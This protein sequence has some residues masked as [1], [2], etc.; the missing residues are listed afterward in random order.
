MSLDQ[1][2]DPTPLGWRDSGTGVLRFFYRIESRS[3][4]TATATGEAEVLAQSRHRRSLID[5]APKARKSLIAETKAMAL[6]RVEPKVNIVEGYVLQNTLWCGHS[7]AH[8]HPELFAALLQTFGP[9]C[10]RPGIAISL[11][12]GWDAIALSVLAVASKEPGGHL[13]EGVHVRSVSMADANVRIDT[14]SAALPLS[15]LLQELLTR[16]PLPKVHRIGFSVLQQGNLREVDVDIDGVTRV[17][18]APS[19]AGLWP[20]R[21]LRRHQ[22]AESLITRVSTAMER[23]RDSLR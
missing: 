8:E 17:V 21:I 18:P 3:V 5:L 16:R 23:A 11:S 10:L 2:N 9:L 12:G 1:N 15:G 13:G 22:E 19:T 20:D 14:K 7:T 4:P 6:G